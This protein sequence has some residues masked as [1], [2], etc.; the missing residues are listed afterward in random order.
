MAKVNVHKIID[1]AIERRDKGI[2]IVVMEN[3]DMS[4]NVYPIHFERPVGRMVYY[5]EGDGRG[6]HYRCSVC[7]QWEWDPLADRYDYCHFCGAALQ[8][9]EEYEDE[10][11]SDEVEYF[12]V[13]ENVDG[14]LD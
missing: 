14:V 8:H 6:A 3:G 12:E 7:G 4:V 5:V 10:G 9:D 13:D 2:S 1:A 11:S